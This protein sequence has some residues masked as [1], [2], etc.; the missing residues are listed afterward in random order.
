MKLKFRAFRAIDDN[1]TCLRYVE[2]H[3]NILKDYGVTNVTSSKNEWIYNPSIYCV[4]AESESGELLGGI[5]VQ[6]A[7]GI[8]PLPVEL[9]IGE[10]DGRIYD[11]V[12]Q[13]TMEGTGELCGLWNSKTVAGYGISVLLVRAGI[14]IINQLK[15]TTLM[16]I[17]GGYT[18]EMFRKVGFVVD[19]SL[20]IDGEFVYPNENYIA[21]VLGILNA[22][23][24]ETADPVDK[25]RMLDLRLNPIQNTK[26]AGPRGGLEVEYNLVVP[27]K[28]SEKTS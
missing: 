9:A 23:T 19:K 28:V 1:E 4:I 16:G 21:W 24:L 20:G 3:V 26:E 14:S 7:D 8:H 15:F 12:K 22:K 27:I 2:G 10:M 5:K 18:L 13:Y 25:E 17:C 6:K 11:I